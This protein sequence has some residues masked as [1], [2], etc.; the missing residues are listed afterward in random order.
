LA[1]K[2]LQRRHAEL[3]EVHISH[4]L[5]QIEQDRY[6]DLLNYLADK[7]DIYP[8]YWQNMEGFKQQLQRWHEEKKP[9]RNLVYDTK[10][11]LDVLHKFA[12]LF[13]VK[14]FVKTLLNIVKDPLML[15]IEKIAEYFKEMRK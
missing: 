8:N 1:R 4:I 15:V 7:V 9:Q 5:Q 10:K 2:E 6:Y 11:S 3:T 12:I 14:Y 13:H